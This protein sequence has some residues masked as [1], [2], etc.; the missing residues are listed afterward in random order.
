[1]L[2]PDFVNWLCND[3][4]RFPGFPETQIAVLNLCNLQVDSWNFDR[5]NNV[6]SR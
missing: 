5:A 3:R 1:M 6:L 2:R 4:Y